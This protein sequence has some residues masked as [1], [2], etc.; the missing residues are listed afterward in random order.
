M[1][2]KK[3]K[4]KISDGSTPLFSMIVRTLSLRQWEVLKMIKT[5]VISGR[6]FPRPAFKRT[7]HI[8][9]SM[10]VGL[11]SCVAGRIKERI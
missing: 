3:D 6:P 5:H 7:P 10:T 4:R 9:S 11:L 1:L 8:K 2:E